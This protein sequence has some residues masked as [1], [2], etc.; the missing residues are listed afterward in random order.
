MK[1]ITAVALL[2]LMLT[3]C[4]T[5]NTEFAIIK[6]QFTG[7]KEGREIHLCK[8]E[9]GK[10]NKVAVTTLGS[11]GRFGFAY[12]VQEPGLYVLNV[13]W[14]Q[15]LKTVKKDHNLKRVYLEN[16]VEL[17]VK[18]SD[19]TYELMAS[20]S[21]Q[22]DCL[23]QW[24]AKVDTVFSYSHGF[25]Y[26][27]LD[28]TNFFP[29]L[30]EFVKAADAFKATINTGDKHFDDLMALMVKTDMQLSALQFIYT[31]RI[32]HPERK[33]YPEY[34]DIVLNEGAPKD[35]R[36]L[37]LPNGADYL[38]LY[39]MYAVMSMPEK[40]ARDKWDLVCM[41]LIQN[42]LLKG[43]F[44]IS[45]LSMFRSYD[46]EYLSFKEQ[47]EPYMVSA[48]LTEELKTFEMGIRQ[49]EEGAEAFDFAGKDVNGQEHKLTDYKGKL[50]YVDVWATWCGPCKAQIPALKELEKQFHGQPI[51]FLSISVDK[52]KDKQK[53][54]DF[55]K[56]NELKGVQ[57]MADKAFDSDVAKAYGINAIPRFMLFDKDGK[58]VT[59]DAPRPSDD[60][61]NEF[62]K[63]YL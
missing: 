14:D 58:I 62:L 12:A 32:K 11:D 4:A 39:T 9:H 36:L 53:W 47:V 10:T 18:I 30:P 37:E 60:K 27:V 55:V 5:K 29:V 6:G 31:P 21:S 24:N 61:I 44:A 54:M 13:V 42:D 17:D 16:G 45:R 52:P 25:S 38:R 56:E 22:N 50:V 34:Y 33:D 35:E 23:A 7:E 40:P 2:A 51:E 15:A 20:N 46:S 49:F 48:Y 41:N 19:G 28:Y 1:F 8:V 59:I 43:Y 63:Q 57:L 26:N 3:S